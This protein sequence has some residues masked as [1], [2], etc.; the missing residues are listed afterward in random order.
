MRR[1]GTGDGTESRERMVIMQSAITNQEAMAVAKCLML[2]V[3]DCDLSSSWYSWLARAAE[4]CRQFLLSALVSSSGISEPLFFFGTLTSLVSTALLSVY[5][6]LQNS[7]YSPV[8]NEQFEF[9]IPS[10]G[11]VPSKYTSFEQ[12][13]F[14]IAIASLLLIDG[15]EQKLIRDPWHPLKSIF[16]HQSMAVALPESPS[17]LQVTSNYSVSPTCKKPRFPFCLGCPYSPG[18]SYVY[19]YPGFYLGSAF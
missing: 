16:V 17:K 13:Y 2:Q 18:P 9:K 12:S 3:D 11:Q 10:C 7:C 8:R 19:T 15:G 4:L 1:K 14:K 5:E 6:L